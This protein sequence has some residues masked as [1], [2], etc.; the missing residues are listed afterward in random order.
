MHA[1][2][3]Q[4]CWNRLAP[5]G[6][7]RPPPLTLLCFPPRLWAAH[8]RKIQLKK[9]KR[10][11]LRSAAVLRGRS[12]PGACTGHRVLLRVPGCRG[13]S[14]PPKGPVLVP[15]WLC[16]PHPCRASALSQAVGEAGSCS[17]RSGGAEVWR[18]VPVQNG[19]RRCKAD[20]CHAFVITAVL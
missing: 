11:R 18:A 3:R 5:A 7:R 16:H 10:L 19:L 8:C 14:S 6:W 20:V 9:G 15:L 13:S 1:A 17:S 4:P 12:P 2:A